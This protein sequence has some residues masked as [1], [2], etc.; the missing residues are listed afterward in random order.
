MTYFAAH[1]F[2]A[3]RRR[4]RP[5]LRVL[6]IRLISLAAAFVVPTVVRADDPSDAPPVRAFCI[7]FNWGEGGPNGFAK[8]GLW[9][10]ASPEEHVA[11]YAALGCNVIQTFAVSCNGYAWYRGGP[12][13][14]QPGLKHDFLTEMVKLGHGRGMR[15][16]GYFCVGANT[17][18]GQTHADSQLRRAQR[19][20]HSVHDRVSRLPVLPRSTMPCGAPTWTGS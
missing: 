6:A 15:V 2:A 1:R 14:P 19:P 20:P 4:P 13:P 11:W 9:A 18:W 12:V 8:P 5:D 3:I 10:D 7:D 16:M 17:L